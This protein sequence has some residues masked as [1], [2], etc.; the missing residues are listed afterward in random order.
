MGYIVISKDGKPVKA[1]GP[2]S[3]DNAWWF[4]G[5]HNYD[6][7]SETPGLYHAGKGHRPGIT[8]QF[9]ENLPEGL[10]V[11]RFQIMM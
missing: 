5:F 1:I 3:T 2:L 6:E 8:G 9:Y 7:D 4:F 11:E 10:P